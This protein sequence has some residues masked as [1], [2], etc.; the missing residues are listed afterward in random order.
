MILSPFDVPRGVSPG[1]VETLACA[2]AEGRVSGI[3]VVECRPSWAARARLL[4]L[5][6]LLLAFGL[7]LLARGPIPLGPLGW[8]L[9]WTG[10]GLGLL[11]LFRPGADAPRYELRASARGLDVPVLRH[12]SRQAV[13]DARHT[14]LRTALGRRRPPRKRR[15]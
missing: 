14:L 4:G 8:G 9:A 5:P 2:L 11:G 6:P 12:A 10:L 7:L 1:Q 13:E 3:R 15:R